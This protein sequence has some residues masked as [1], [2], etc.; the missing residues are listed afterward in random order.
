[1][2]STKHSTLYCDYRLICQ[3]FL[4]IMHVRKNDKKTPTIQKYG[5][6]KALG[7]WEALFP[8]NILLQECRDRLRD[9]YACFI[10]YEKALDSI[11]NVKLI[12]ILQKIGAVSS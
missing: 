8:L 1:M 6:C 10:E 3:D 11:N 5:F 12:E 2:K 9:A 7:K 4:L